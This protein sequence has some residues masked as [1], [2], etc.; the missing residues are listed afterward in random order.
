MEED[1]WIIDGQKVLLDEDTVIENP[2]LAEVGAW[3]VV[4]AL[5]QPNGSLLAQYIT[6]TRGAEKPPQ[7][8]EF[9]GLVESFSDT[10]WVVAGRTVL[11]NEDTVIEGTPQVGAVARV[12][13]LQQ[14]DGS[15]LATR[16]VIEERVV[17]FE[18]PILE[19]S[20]QVWVIAGRR[21]EVDANTVVVGT[22]RVGALAEVQAIERADGALLAT[23]IEIQEPEPTPTPTPTTPHT[24][25]LTPSPT[26]PSEPTST[27]QATE[28]LEPTP[29][30][31]ASETP[32]PTATLSPTETPTETGEP[33]SAKP[34]VTSEETA[35]PTVKREA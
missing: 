26:E 35:T 34:T 5:R 18:G 27:P 1:Y 2:D 24:P 11:I 21:V 31:Q 25:T 14:A 6:I 29:T 23:R 22:P 30:P 8:I 19:I 28:T 16:I 17:E 13:A 32:E 9:K 3:A 12:Q 7:P 33:S 4:Q 15:L 20:P 10:V